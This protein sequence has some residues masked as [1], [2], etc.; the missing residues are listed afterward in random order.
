MVRPAGF[1]SRLDREQLTS[2]VN[3]RASEMLHR[4]LVHSGALG[5]ESSYAAKLLACFEFI[6]SG[7]DETSS[8]W[9]NLTRA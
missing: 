6:E 9:E 7:T 2:L 5:D 8:Q 3:D 1:T 4:D